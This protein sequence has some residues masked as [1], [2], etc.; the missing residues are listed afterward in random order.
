MVHLYN[1][2]DYII[3]LLILD[4]EQNIVLDKEVIV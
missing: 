1:K 4:E 3:Y 2:K